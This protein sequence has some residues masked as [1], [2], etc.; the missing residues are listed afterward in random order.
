M[1]PMFCSS[2]ATLLAPTRVDV[3]RGSRSVQASASWA[4]VGRAVRPLSRRA[5]TF[6]GLLGELGGDRGSRLAGPRA[7]GHPVEIGS[8]SSPWA[9]G[10]KTMQPT[11]RSP[12][13]CTSPYSGHRLKR[14]KEG[15]DEERRAELRRDAAACAVCSG[16]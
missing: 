7:L 8:V 2:W 1:V 11:P 3:T 5:R 13:V 10:E 4:M 12:S 16:G 6:Q 15:M 14:E 9:R